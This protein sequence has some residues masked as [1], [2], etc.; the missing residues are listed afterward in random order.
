MAKA[1][2]ISV[3]IDPELKARLEQMAAETKMTVAAFAERSL[4]LHSRGG[5]LPT[6]MLIYPEIQHSERNG[7]TI[8]LPIA[9]G[10]PM[11][12]LPIDHAE[13]LGNQ[14]LAAVKAAKRLNE[15]SEKDPYEEIPDDHHPF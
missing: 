12:L 13:M 7:T 14:L 6:W 11:A 2:S 10:W 8:S 5:K 15:R 3:R 1:S 9:N 4:D